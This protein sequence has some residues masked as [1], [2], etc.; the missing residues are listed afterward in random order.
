MTPQEYLLRPRDIRQ[1]IL[2]KK[3]RID[4]L[5]RHSARLTSVLRD[6][7]V[8]TSPDPAFVQEILAEIADEERAVLRLREEHTRALTGI[9]LYISQL[10]AAYAELLELRYL[11]SCSWTR[12]MDRLGYSRTSVFRIHRRALDLLPPPPEDPA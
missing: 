6:V 4:S 10:P 2:R 1:Q 11:D 3:D 9:A 5:R 12:I 8:K 7:R